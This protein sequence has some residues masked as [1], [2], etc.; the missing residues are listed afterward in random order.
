MTNI[1]SIIASDETNQFPQPIKAWERLNRNS[2]NSAGVSIEVPIIT[3]AEKLL[4]SMIFFQ[5]K[6]YELQPSLQPLCRNL[7]DSLKD[8]YNSSYG[9]S[10]GQI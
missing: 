10:R 9:L 5:A 2:L 1:T 6:F 3:S 7:I 8:F 4:S